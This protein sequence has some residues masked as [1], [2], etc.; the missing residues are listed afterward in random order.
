MRP[1]AIAAAAALLALQPQTALAQA[2]DAAPSEALVER[3]LAVLPDR[4]EIDALSAEVDPAELSTLAALNPGRE[5]QVRSILEANLAC[6]G[7]AISAGTL[8]ML[9]TVARDLGEAKVQRLVDFYEG[10]DYAAFAALGLRMGG[11]TAPSA[12]DRAAMA[13]LMEAY[14]LQAWLDGLNRAQEIFEADKGF[15]SAA[16]KC[17]REQ[18][19]ALEAAGLKSH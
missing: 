8:R 7:A 9:R 15:M 1:L 2:A 3:F 11:A 4:D 14:P 13:K 6:S 19:T 12:E 18:M 16:M 17:A 5:A 10:P